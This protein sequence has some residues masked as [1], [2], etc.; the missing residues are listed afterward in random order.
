MFTEISELDSATANKVMLCCEELMYNLVQFGTDKDKDRNFDIH[1]SD[2]E[3]RFEVRI[4]DAGK[5][6]NP[7]I[8]FDKTAAQAYKDGESMQLGLHIVNKMCDEIGHKFMFGLNVTTLSFQK[9]I[10]EY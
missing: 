2:L 8:K 4:K 6:F 9:V 3:D 5:P 1:L 10:E 7:V